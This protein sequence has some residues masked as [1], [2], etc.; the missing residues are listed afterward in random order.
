MSKYGIGL[1]WLTSMA[2]EVMAERG[3]HQVSPCT[4]SP[5]QN[6]NLFI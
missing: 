2:L 5:S 1:G 3:I 4:Q 6:S